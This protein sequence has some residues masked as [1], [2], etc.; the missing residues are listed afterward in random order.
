MKTVF[1]FLL[2]GL[3]ACQ[4]PMF[5]RSKPEEG[6]T[7][8]P[9]TFGTRALISILHDPLRSKEDALLAVETLNER[10]MG[11]EDGVFLMRAA[12]EHP[13]E[14]V[15]LQI[16]T[17]IG[18]QRLRY[19]YPVLMSFVG[20]ATSA[21]IAVRALDAAVAVSRE[22]KVLYRDLSRL[23]LTAERAEVRARA[24]VQLTKRF[25]FES[26]E[27]FVEALEDEASASVASMMTEYLA[28][29]GTRLSLPI[30][31]EISNDIERVYATDEFMG[32]SFTSESV[33]GGA[34]QAVQRLRK[35]Q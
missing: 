22:D 34:V 2:F 19:L 11:R 32:K 3:S 21:Q 27:V 31:E 28:M 33:R 7:Y 12:M 35:K 30:L 9:E 8:D 6:P 10:E 25:P 15:K 24:G 29:K 1:L 14:E 18:R 13:S 23:I 20:E 4:S 5:S 16:L 17:A 26:E